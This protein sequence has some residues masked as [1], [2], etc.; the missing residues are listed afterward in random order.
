MSLA[1]DVDVPGMKGGGLGGLVSFKAGLADLTGVFQFAD[2]PE[3][4]PV[5]HLG[6]PLQVTFYGE[7]PTLRTGRDEELVLVVGTP[8]TGPG[9]FAMLNYEGTVPEGLKPVADVVLPPV[10][11]GGPSGK[12]K[13]E[14]RDRC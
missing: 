4:A 13:W 14:I 8:G 5:V 2:R 10:R 9:T 12:E 3:N 11:S 6:G 1:V 7:R